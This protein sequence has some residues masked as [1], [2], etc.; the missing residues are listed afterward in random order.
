MEKPFYG[1]VLSFVCAS[2]VAGTLIGCG[3]ESFEDRGIEVGSRAEAL[4]GDTAISAASD[5]ER[6][7]ASAAGEH[8]LRAAGIRMGL[9]EGE[10]SFKS[11]LGEALA[12]T[13]PG[14]PN[15][16]VNNSGA[17]TPENT[18][19][20]E[21]T[22]AVLGNTICAGYNDSGPGGLS[23]LARSADGGLTW[24]D[25]GGLGQSGDPVLA[26][27]RASGTFYYA[28]IATIG[29]LPA[30]GVARSTNDCLTFGAPV[31]ASPVASGLPDTF[32]NDKPWIAVDNT[33]GA[34]DGNI[35]ACWTRFTLATSELRF[36]RSIDGGLT[37]QNEQILLAAGTAPFGCSVA[38][39]PSGDVHVAWADRTGATANDIR[40][41]SSADAGLNF[42]AAVTIS[43]GNRHPGNDSQVF[44]PPNIRPTLNGNIRML[45]QA[46]L[47]ADTT[48]GPFSGNLYVVWASDPVG[49]PDNSDAFFSRSVDGGATWSAAVQIGAG[50]GATDQFEPFVTVGGLGAVA[51]AWYDRRNDPT[52]NNLIDV[53]TTFSRDG[54]V[55]LDPLTR[56]TTVNFGVPPLNPNFDPNIVSCY[57][58][59]Y[60]AVAGD[61]ERFYYLWGDNRNT[62]VTP[63]FPAGRLDPDVFFD[64]LDASPEP[65]CGGLAPTIVG[66]N[67]SNLLFG[68]SGRDIISG[69]G[70]ND[71]IFGLGGADILCGGTGNDEFEGG[72]GNDFIFGG[73]GNDSV[74]GDSGDD[75]ALGQDGSD[76]L[77]GDIGGDTLNGGNGFD[78]LHGGFDLS[79]DSCTQGEIVLFCP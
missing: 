10:S 40:I 41:R 70:G 51:I 28:E 18:T 48:T 3:S 17:D 69:L 9:R 76:F 50:G 8:S 58:G 68:T 19:Q 32:L 44:C 37:F 45:H 5:F 38:V 65:N 53:F 11:P 73:A 15:I 43:T 20:S 35:Y 39:D 55:T 24:T 21:T 52:N 71:D 7:G 63:A 78:T 77:F 27:H 12:L 42:A 1:R 61:T 54:G 25:L 6:Y 75:F 33:G 47:A 56:V 74:D 59:E 26:V 29:G 23:G 4:T 13:L 31:D 66:T 79:V 67:S 64:R 34:A 2:C 14:A 30:I 62:I 60:I 46:W 16:Q 36:S 22:L 57:M 72:S 49:L